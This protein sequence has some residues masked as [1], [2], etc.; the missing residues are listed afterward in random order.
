MRKLIMFNM[1][2]LDGFFAGPGGEI[3]WH[4]VDGEF[5]DFAV[6]QLETAGGLLFGRITYELMASYWPTE[7]AIKDDPVVADK[8]NGLA[9]YVCSRTLTTAGWANTTLL[10][11]NAVQEI[12]KLKG[13]SGRD[14]FLFG[15]ADLASHLVD[16]IDEYRV[17]VNPVVLGSGKPLF[18]GVKERL[19]LHLA[20]TKVFRSGNVLLFYQP[21]LT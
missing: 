2:T 4:H 19:N 15:S 7:T 13:Q 6:A 8:M 10:K 3:D 5:N 1:A 21:R 18:K 20:S 16:L 9:K 11:G 12:T 17:M 14:L